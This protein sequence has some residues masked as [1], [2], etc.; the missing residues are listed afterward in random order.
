MLGEESMY[1]PVSCNLRLQAN[2]IRLTTGQL[3]HRKMAL[4]NVLPI[5]MLILCALFV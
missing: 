3:F 1:I 2:I 4:E 5:L